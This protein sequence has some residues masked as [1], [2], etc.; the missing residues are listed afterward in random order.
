MKASVAVLSTII[1]L[2]AMAS[3]PAGAMEQCQ[4]Q[5]SVKEGHASTEKHAKS[6]CK[7]HLRQKA[8]AV[9]GTNYHLKDS[10]ISCF[11]QGD[12]PQWYGKQWSCICSAYICRFIE[13]LKW[14]P[15]VELKHSPFSVPSRPPSG[16]PSGLPGARR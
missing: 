3:V 12:G 6:L 13:R 14:Q 7:L 1:G 11:H 9:Y 4:K 5:R 16:R 8:A 15:P 10:S 2:L